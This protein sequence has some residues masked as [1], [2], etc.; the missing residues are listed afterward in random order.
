MDLK[1][2]QGYEE[3]VHWLEDWN[4]RRQMAVAQV[5]CYVVSAIYL[6]GMCYPRQSTAS[7]K[8]KKRKAL[9]DAECKREFE[10][11]RE[12]INNVAEAIREGNAV[13]ERGRARIYSEDDIFTELVNIGL[14]QNILYSAYIFLIKD[15]ARVRAFFGCPA[16]ER[17]NFLL[18]IMDASQELY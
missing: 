9:L 17:K 16:E 15:A 13:I 2:I 10:S 12:A 7:P 8:G 5:L 1:D 4:R 14:D 11:I 6:F 3:E 18:H